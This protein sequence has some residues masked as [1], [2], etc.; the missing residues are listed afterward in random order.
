[1]TTIT[2]PSPL[3]PL[4]A[5]L[6]APRRFTLLD[7]AQVVPNAD[8]DR[9]PG[10][11]WTEGYPAGPVGTQDPCSTGTDRAKT[12]GGQIASQMAGA[13][14]A[15][16]YGQCAAQSVGPDPTFW[17]DRLTLAFEALESTAVE[18]VLAT[19]DGH[20]SLGP[21]L[22]DQNLE[23]LASGGAQT[24]TEGLAL[25]EQRIAELGTGIIHVTPAV[26]TYWLSETLLVSKANVLYTGLGTPVAV[27]AGY[28][29]ATPSGSLTSGQEWAF[30][31]GPIQVIRSGPRPIVNPVNYFEA[32][33]RSLN[34]VAFLAERHYLLNWV[35]RQDP[36]DPDHL[37]A[38]VLIDRTP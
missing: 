1:M 37:Q 22:T 3:V 20:A 33:D 12:P 10:G 19:G 29:G 21:F 17:T 26:A 8:G 6:P 32:F 36:S 38:G 14:T 5:P 13:F 9:F 30:A 34:D 11:A 7:T 18:R 35:A 15:Y 23:Q 25:L 24:P 16:L 28:I 31:T 4:S 27:G 2:A